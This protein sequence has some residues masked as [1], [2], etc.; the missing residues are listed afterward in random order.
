[1]SNPSVAVI[2]ILLV[3]V[4]YSASL[5]RLFSNSKHE[6]ITLLISLKIQ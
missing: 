4:A 1:M 3:N 2:N 6:N 5:N